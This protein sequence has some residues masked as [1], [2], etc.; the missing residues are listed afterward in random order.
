MPYAN[1]AA[2]IIY[3]FF[4]CYVG[5]REDKTAV[6]RLFVLLI[7]LFANWS[8]WDFLTQ[9]N[10][11]PD[12]HVIFCFRVGAIGW[13]FCAPVLFW[14][15]AS[16]ARARSILSAPLIALSF[17]PAV[18]MLWAQWQGYMVIGFAQTPFGRN[19]VWSSSVFP[20]LFHLHHLAFFAGSAFLLVAHGVR[21]PHPTQRRHGQI[22]AL[23]AGIMV[24]FG[25]ATEILIPEFFAANF[26]NMGQLALLPVI[27]IGIWAV[28][29]MDLLSYHPANMSHSI[30]ESMHD[31]VLLLD[32]SA[33]IRRANPAVLKMMS[34]T[35]DQVEG[36]EFEAF[37]AHTSWDELIK[38]R[39][40][41][42]LG[43]YPQQK[44]SEERGQAWILKK[45]DGT[46]MPVAISF[47]S[48]GTAS[49]FPRGTIGLVHDMSRVYKHLADLDEN[50][51]Y[52]LKANRKMGKIMEAKQVLTAQTMEASMQK[53]H[54]LANMSHEIRTPL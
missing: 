12:Q 5:F 23:I 8:F 25:F 17:L 39:L 32:G 44:T 21:A 51:E 38:G 9:S 24:L 31:G 13:I 41:K 50:T 7:L 4:A 10:L 26:P 46:S 3:L 48:L 35:R 34:S 47:S 15:S 36:V 2:T 49:N 33:I 45:S 52:L 1:L 54:F 6:K 40:A 19:G 29:R 37:F 53:T 11:L 30:F 27:P 22:L 18:L 20:L 16:F 43:N 28:A 14:F 42:V